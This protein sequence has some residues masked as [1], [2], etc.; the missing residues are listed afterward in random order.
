ML[1]T[2][3]SAEKIVSHLTKITELDRFN[4]LIVIID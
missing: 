3:V 2:I 4:E 1:E